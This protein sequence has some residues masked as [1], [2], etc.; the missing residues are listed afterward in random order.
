L[1]PVTG[2]LI[3]DYYKIAQHDLSVIWPLFNQWSLL[4]RWQHDYNRSRNLERLFGVEYDS[5][6][7]K[8]RLVAREWLDDDQYSLSPVLN[9]KPDRGVFLQIVFKG[10]GGI[11][12]NKVES[13][14]N[15]I[16]GYQQREKRGF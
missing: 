7:W 10:L 15:G 4:G 12:G 5:C 8:A 13:F 16:E 2:K 6:C 14:M 11:A 1:D 3:H 9:E